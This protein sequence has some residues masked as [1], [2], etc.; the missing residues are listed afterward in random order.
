MKVTCAACGAA[1]EVEP[2]S[3][4]VSTG[5]AFQMPCPSCGADVEVRPTGLAM[6]Q[7]GAMRSIQPITPPDLPTPTAAAPASPPAADEPTVAPKT[8]PAALE[9]RPRTSVSRTPAPTLAPSFDEDDD[10]DDGPTDNGRTGRPTAPLPPVTPV[11]NEASPPS[12]PPAL[13]GL[14][15]D[16][17]DP[18]L[19]ASRAGRLGNGKSSSSTDDKRLILRQDGERYLV[20]D[21]ATLQRWI[22]EQRVEPDDELQVGTG[23]FRTMRELPEYSV[24]FDAVH[25]L[26]ERGEAPDGPTTGAGHNDPD[27]ADI[28]PP[29]PRRVISEEAPA[30]N[31]PAS[32]DDWTDESPPIPTEEEVLPDDDRG[33]I[34]F[35]PPSQ[36]TSNIQ[37]PDPIT[38]EVV[39][40]D[41]IEGWSDFEPDPSAYRDDKRMLLVMVSVAAVI[42]MIGLWA[43]LGTGGGTPDDA[44]AVAAE[45]PADPAPGTV[46]AAAAAE[47]APAPIEEPAPAPEP[48]PDPVEDPEPEPEPEPAK[49]T[50]APT[51]APAPKPTPAPKPVAKPAP[52]PAPAA[53]KPAPKPTASRRSGSGEAPVPQL[54]GTAPQN[55]PY[56]SLIDAGWSAIDRKDS[57]T[58]IAM[59]QRAV[60]LQPSGVEATYGLGY[61]LLESGRPKAGATYL[62]RALVRGDDAM[63]AEIKGLMNRR[64]LSCP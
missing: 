3:W 64:S 34:G 30:P 28:K 25:R 54:A 27:S 58:S 33:L 15:G 44:P 14:M 49:A 26:E 29:P 32:D 51:P 55:V 48:A 39:F 9:P 50:A 5:R 42:L 38:D 18:A 40:G 23:S 36:S 35:E 24:F 59:F 61:A 47:P 10:G 22:M 19:P 57:V 45:V 2:P 4:L 56:A 7:S 52:K 63:I 20:K 1:H 12:A 31:L 13:A 46:P 41:D 43:V 6:L 37:A 17:V 11:P 62:C 60:E 8:R 21:V 53:A 16:E